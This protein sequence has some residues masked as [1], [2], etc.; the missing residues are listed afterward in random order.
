MVEIRSVGVCLTPE[1]GADDMLL[2][3]RIVPDGREGSTV[4]AR[5]LLPGEKYSEPPVVVQPELGE[6]LVIPKGKCKI[7]LVDIDRMSEKRPS[8]YISLANTIWTW[9]QI[10]PTT[11]PEQFRYLLSAA[12][13]LDTAHDQLASLHTILSDPPTGFFRMR[14]AAFQAL[15]L[16]ETCVVSLSRALDMTCRYSQEFSSAIPLPK[17]VNSV[18]EDVRQ[19]RNAFEHIEDR[20]LGRVHGKPDAD[21]LSIFN[22][23]KLFSEAIVSY[24]GH[25]LELREQAARIISVL[26][27]HLFELTATVSA[28]AK[29]S[30]KPL[31]FFAGDNG[32]QKD[33]GITMG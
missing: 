15:G 28:H 25:S 19:L 8:G 9:L 16:A 21:A 20:A 7:S 24:A 11:T 29:T 17:E 4:F 30:D 1:V 14:Q 18:R 22:Q 26:R 2:Q 33:G 32:D 31:V 27:D 12:R 6:R 23:S 5:T 3:V 13:R 10:S